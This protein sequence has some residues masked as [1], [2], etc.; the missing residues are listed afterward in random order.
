MVRAVIF[1]LGNVIVPFDPQRR[2][3][4]FAAV[5]PYTTAEISSRVAASGLAQRFETGQVSPQEFYHG[6]CRTLDLQVSYSEF[7]RIWSSIFLPETLIPESLL[8][9]LHLRYRL[10]ML[11][12]TDPIHFSTIGKNYPIIRHFDARVLSYEVGARKPSSRIF[13]AAIARAGFP[14]SQCLFTDD[15]AANVEAARNE[16]M[17]AVQFRSLPQLEA[18][19]RAYGVEWE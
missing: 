18:E 5:C 4:E 1:D 11:S 19:F 6:I 16:G 13:Q 17:V 8:E 14:A 9:S 15:S 7:C 2:V 12:D 3:L 10:L